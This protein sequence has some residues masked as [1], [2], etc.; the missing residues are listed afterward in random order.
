M[1]IVIDTNVVIA[2]L[3]SRRGASFQILKAALKGVVDYA[4]SPLIALEYIGKVEDKIE[5]GLL[6]QPREVYFPIL[7]ALIDNGIQIRQPSPQRPVLKDVTDDKILE[8]AI[9]AKCD[10]IITFN[11]RDFPGS[12]I[13]RY[14]IKAVLP[15]TFIKEGMK[16]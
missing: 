5:D 1:R 10:A 3:Y 12:V 11:V 9:T 8:C 15:G 2:G 13:N 7:K 6:K 14:H 4:V 16:L